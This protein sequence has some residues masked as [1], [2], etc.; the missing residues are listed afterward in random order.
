M[1]YLLSGAIEGP[2]VVG[3]V[4]GAVVAERPVAYTPSSPA[5]LAIAGTPAHDRSG[6]RHHRE[7][8]VLLLNR[9]PLLVGRD[10]TPS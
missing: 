10:L 4:G 3:S 8:Q 9:A 5:T 2:A 1:K 7:R 6:S